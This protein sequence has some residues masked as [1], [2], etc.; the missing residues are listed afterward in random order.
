MKSPPWTPEQDQ[1]LKAWY[2]R[3]PFATVQRGINKR[4]PARTITA[5]H[6]HA[7]NMGFNGQ[8]IP[9]GY[10]ALAEALPRYCGTRA[11][12]RLVRAA[13]RAGVAKR[14][15]H[16]RGKPVIAPEEWIDNWLRENTSDTTRDRYYQTHWLSSKEFAA[17][18]GIRSNS[19]ASA[20]TQTLKRLNELEGVRRVRLLSRPAHPIYWHPEDAQRIMLLRRERS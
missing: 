2:G 20:I 5:M 7:R 11:K 4:G 15:Q 16:Q 9:A 10:A 18:I 6:V 3:K 14:L 19:P 12:T 1:Y 17:R 13:E 8:R